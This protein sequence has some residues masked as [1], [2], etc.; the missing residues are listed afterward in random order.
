M[1]FAVAGPQYPEDIDWPANVDRIG[2]LPPAEHAEFY[3]ASRYA[4]NVTR[5]DMVRMGWSPSVRLFEAAATGTPIISDPWPGLGNFLEP[6]EEII[7]ATETDRVIRMLAR[8]R[9][10]VGRAARTRILSEHSGQHRAAEL[11]FHLTQATRAVMAAPYFQS[12]EPQRK[13]R[14]TT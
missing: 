11:E 6:D 3:N 10:D 9:T 4:L 2:H 12:A 13:S 8:D 5:A 1:R 7:L 14:S